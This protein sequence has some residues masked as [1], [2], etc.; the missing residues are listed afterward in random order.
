VPTVGVIV[1]ECVFVFGPP[2]PAALAVTVVEP[3]QPGAY[4][5]SPVVALIVFPPARL[6]A[7][8]L[9][10]MDVAYDDVAV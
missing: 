10:V 6:A 8:K 3:L 4:V 9:Y 2:H 7:S 5:T 1:T